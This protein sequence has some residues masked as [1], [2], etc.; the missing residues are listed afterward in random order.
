MT[1]GGYFLRG[2]RYMQR[3]LALLLTVVCVVLASEAVGGFKAEAGPIKLTYSNFFPPT[4]IQSKL[5]E[6][7]CREV[8]KRTNGRVVVEYFPG[9]TL[10]KARQVYDGVVTGLSDIG[11]ALFAYT[12][13]RFP[14][15]AAVDLPLGYPSGKVATKVVNAVYRKFRPKELNDTQVMYLHAHGPGILHTKS[16]AVRR[17][18]DLKGMKLRGHGTS[19]QI[20]KALGATPVSMPMPELYQSLQKGVVEGA[21]YPIEV[22]KGWRMGEV[23]K[24][25]TATFSIAY[26]SS[27]F[28]VMNKEKWN[29]LPPEIQRIIE[30]INEEWI[31]KH[32]EA[33]DSSD[34]EGY[35]Y[36]LSL[37]HEIIG[38]DSREAARWKKAVAPV[39]E[40]YIR[41]M[42]KKGFDGKEIVDFT[43]ATLN[44]YKK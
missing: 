18:E 34:M 44:K 6:A 13:G 10:T 11:L 39:V 20:A 19:A 32:G 36:S 35:L 31:P 4:H 1:G 15:M 27:F 2:E 30:E 37:G 8:E 17:L 41:D 5:A 23:T 33:W 38:L 42:N 9:Q 16:K 43:I 40:Q 29:A 21:L 24:Y 3:R 25:T 14:V 26:T 28:V 22:N 7:W 12:R